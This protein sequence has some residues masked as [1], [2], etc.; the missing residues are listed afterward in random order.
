MSESQYGRTSIVKSLQETAAHTLTRVRFEKGGGGEYNERWLQEFISRYP[1][2]L[3]IDK[4]EPALAQAISI[5]M[6]LPLADFFVDNFFV[7]PDGDLIIGETK[8]FRNPEARRAVVGQVMEYAKHLSMLSYEELQSAILRGELPDGTKGSPKATLYE[9]VTAASD[10]SQTKSEERFIDAVSRNLERGRFLILII[11][12]GIQEGTENIAT[13]L[14]DH[15]GMHFTFGLVD[16]AIFNLPAGMPGYL[17]QPRVLARTKNI[18]R[19]VITIE[20]GQITITAPVTVTPLSGHE[21]KRT[22]IT[23]EKFYEELSGSFPQAVPKL[24]AF[25]AR[26]E[27]IGLEIDFGKDSLILRGRNQGR[28]P[29][30]LATITTSGKVWTDLL[31]GQANA[32]GLLHLSHAYLKQV[33]DAVPGAIV[34]HNPKETAW[35]VAKNGTY[36]MIDE[37]LAHE[38]EWLAAI[39]AFMLAATNA[40]DLK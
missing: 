5:C 23:E 1:S 9:L 37:L 22:T 30:N 14:N 34:K 17:V 16:L 15:A 6:E 28:T 3:P 33:A 27:A 7:T 29:W 10:P 11:G 31:N 12:D 36:I 24:R 35:Y 21:G 20:K 18:D 25:A 4:I 2:V 40:L 39:Q 13:Y 26:L 32:V 38:D 19:G 8:L